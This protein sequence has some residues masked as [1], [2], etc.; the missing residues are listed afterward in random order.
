MFLQKAIVIL[1]GNNGILI[2]NSNGKDIEQKFIESLN[3]NNRAELV[4]FFKKHQSQKIYILLDTID[5]TYKK[6]SYPSIKKSDLEKIIKRDLAGDGDKEALKNYII[7]KKTKVENVKLTLNFNKNTT[8]KLDCLFISSSKSQLIT[9]WLNFIYE[10]PNRL[11]GVYML[12][13]ES[14]NFYQNLYKIK[15]IEKNKNKITDPQLQKI[16]NTDIHCLVIQTDVGGAR[17]IVF[18][19]ENI[20]FTR[21]VNYN[22]ADENFAE[23]YI[24]DIY[25][26]FEYLKRMFIELTIDKFQIINIFPESA[27]QRIISI[28]NQEIQQINHTPEQAK[29]MI[30]AKN[31]KTNSNISFDL[32]IIMAF[33]KEKSILKFT[34]HK[35]KEL[36]TAYLQF[37]SV[38]IANI[39]MLAILVFGLLFLF[40]SNK[41]VVSDIET[42]E[43]E[44]INLSK[45]LSLARKVAIEG[46]S[47]EGEDQDISIERIGDIGRVE[48]VLG[49]FQPN[50][51]QTY[52]Q[53]SFARDS[54]EITNFKYKTTDFITKSP[55]KGAK[56]EMVFNGI[57]F[58]RTGSIDDLFIEFDSFINKKLK[59]TLT[60]FDVK[61]TE[62]N[63]NIDFNAK[64]YEQPI[65]FT[66]LEKR[67]TNETAKTVNPDKNQVKENENN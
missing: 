11:I 7:L 60:N 4:D 19:G 8:G 22:I 67:A 61:Y 33:L 12:P 17:Q 5:Q 63:R 41:T 26:T 29:E 14:Y 39:T 57:L 6:K 10:L 40:I 62:I 34:T 46:A 16:L 45:S 31:I 9:D 44:K 32:L 53:L 20:V 56:K 30:G 25:S 66:L 54:V 38:L 50:F 51:A 3:E 55:N 23:K 13:I 28:G 27:F 65:E 2:A 15:E 48:E 43:N 37:K 59:S 58:N 21:V 64:F 42:A 18:S 52:A 49:D 36:E 1:I 47:L 24:Q 35:I